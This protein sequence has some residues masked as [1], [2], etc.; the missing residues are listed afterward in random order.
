MIDFIES[1]QG[2]GYS[3]KPFGA[4]AL[5]YVLVYV[6]F[7]GTGFSRDVLSS[8][9]MQKPSALKRSPTCGVC[10]FFVGT[11][12]SRDVLSSGNVQTNRR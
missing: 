9:N 8:G 1:Q 2:S 11:G 5:S 4:K 10:V 3:Q 7:V 12:F 6:F